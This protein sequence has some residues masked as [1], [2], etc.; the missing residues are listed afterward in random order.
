MCSERATE[1]SWEISELDPSWAMWWGFC[2]EISIRLPNRRSRRTGGR[3]MEWEGT[4]G[5]RWGF[6][7]EFSVGPEIGKVEGCVV[8]NLNGPQIGYVL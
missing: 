8:G 5:T 4:Q 3:K 1:V 2:L 7:L 6:S